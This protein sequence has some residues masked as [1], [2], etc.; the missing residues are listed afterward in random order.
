MLFVMLDLSAAF[1][2]IDHAHLLTLRQEGYGVR[3]TALAWFPTYVEDRNYRI[4]IE[5]T[6]L[7]HIPLRCGVPQ[8][9]VLGPVMFT[10]YTT[11]MQRIS[12]W[13]RSMATG[14][15]VSCCV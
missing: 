12:K 3:G 15:W 6:T 8:G 9:S 11:P 7:E 1:N 4:Q 5:T 10:L 14:C 2:T 13:R